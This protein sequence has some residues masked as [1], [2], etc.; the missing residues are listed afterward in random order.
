[1]ELLVGARQVAGF[2]QQLLLVL[3]G[4][5]DVQR[6]G[7]DLAGQRGAGRGQQMTVGLGI[8]ARLHQQAAAGHRR[9]GHGCLELRV[10]ASAGAF[11]GVGPAMVED[12]FAHGVALQVAGH[13]RGRLAVGAVEHQ[14]LAEPAALARRRARFLQRP[15][16]VVRQE[17][18]GGLAGRVGA[19]IP[20]VA[21][22]I[23]ERGQDTEGGLRRKGDGHEQGLSEKGTAINLEPLEFRARRRWRVGTSERR[24]TNVRHP[25]ASEARSEDRSR[26]ANAR[27]IRRSRSSGQAG[28]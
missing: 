14:V 28:G 12:I 25:P 7:A 5:G 1:M 27:R 4:E 17:R 13:D 21:G 3:R 16:K 26:Q 6:R 15:Q 2:G 8:R 22:D 10:V 23:A 19:G 9:E 20:V 11:K 24:N 18:V